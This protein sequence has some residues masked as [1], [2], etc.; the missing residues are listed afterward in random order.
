MDRSVMWWIGDWWRYGDHEYGDRAAQAL[1]QDTFS[2]QTFMDAGWVSGRV[3][4]S[5]RREV[6]SWSHHREVAALEPAEQDEWLDRAESEGWSRNELRREIRRPNITALP[7]G[8]GTVSIEHAD[9]HDYLAGIAPGSFDLL[10]TDPPYMTDV[11]VPVCDFASAWLP[12]ALDAITPTGRAYVC[13]GAYPEELRAYLTVVLAREDWRVDA[14]LVWTYRNTL[15]PAPARQYKLNWQAILHLWRPESPPLDC[16]VMVEQFTV[17]DITAP[18]GRHGTRLHAWQKPDELAERLIRHSTRPGDRV[19]DPFA[20]T[21][22]FVA[23]AS[24]LGRHGAG[25]DHDPAMTDHHERRGMAHA[26]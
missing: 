10:L 4:T 7:A 14:P 2:Y 21:G 20:G 25:C 18:D 22:T 9:A 19:L 3:E 6:L 23:A 13:V 16:P 17:Q 15:G 24:R 12:A 1:D 5:R 11:P 8:E 26:A